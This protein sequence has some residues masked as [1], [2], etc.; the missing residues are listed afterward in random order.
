MVVCVEYRLHGH[1]S[2]RTAIVVSKE[3]QWEWKIVFIQLLLWSQ[4]Q[5]ASNKC[6]LKIAKKKKKLKGKVKMKKPFPV[7]LLS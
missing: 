2:M 7:K 5:L 4:R 6:V 3:R 1:K